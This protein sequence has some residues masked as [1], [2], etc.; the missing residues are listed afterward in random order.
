MPSAIMRSYHRYEGGS[1]GRR[2]RRVLAAAIR[3]LA[4]RDHEA[5]RIYIE[6]AFQ[7]ERELRNAFRRLRRSL[8]DELRFG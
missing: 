5:V 3:L 2:R 8:R 4:N 1:T 6:C 7:G